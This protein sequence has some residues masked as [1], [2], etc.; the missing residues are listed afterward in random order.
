MSG[1][2]LFAALVERVRTATVMIVYSQ[3]TM[4]RQQSEFRTVASFPPFLEFKC[5]TLGFN[6]VHELT[7]LHHLTRAVIAVIYCNNYQYGQGA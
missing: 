5:F 6:R 3:R 4:F 7:G 1:R 2:V